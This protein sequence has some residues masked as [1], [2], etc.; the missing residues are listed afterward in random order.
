[1]T[2]IFT[3]RRLFSV[4]LSTA[5][6]VMPALARHDSQNTVFTERDSAAFVNAAWNWNTAVN[7]AEYATVQ[8]EMFNSVQTVSVVRYPLRRFRT[9]VIHCPGEDRG[10][11][12]E[13]GMEGHAG[14]AINGGYFNM[15]TLYPVTYL[16]VKGHEKGYVDKDEITYR[17]NGAVAFSRRGIQ[18][19][20]CDTSGYGHI[21]SRCL[22][23]L[24]AGP[25]LV[26]DGNI[27]DYTD[28]SSFYSSRHPR[29][30]IGYT[31][32]GM[33]YMVVIDGRFNGLADGATI[34]EAAFIARM[35]G[36]DAA[37]NLDGGGS[38]SLWISGKGVLSHPT[39]NRKFDHEGEREVPNC[40]IATAR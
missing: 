10:T 14:F 1:M 32:D 11:V 20:V 22:D 34:A 8:I 15:G 30:F 39:D 21:P 9:G 7:G 17:S 24:A 2:K 12:S 37:L 18:I 4:I 40:I 6:F 33:V 5:A 36:L 19:Y 25:V 27:V 38:S 31:S 16:R 29:S 26:Y 28:D 23:V 13:I 3:G 35:L